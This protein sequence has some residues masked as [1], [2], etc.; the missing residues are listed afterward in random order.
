MIKFLQDFYGLMTNDTAKS[1]VT[2][3]FLE[4]YIFWN[5]GRACLILF[6][7]IFF[8]FLLRFIHHS[9]LFSSD[10]LCIWIIFLW[11]APCILPNYFHS[12]NR[13]WLFYFYNSFFDFPVKPLEV[14]S[15]YLILSKEYT[16]LF[17][18]SCSQCL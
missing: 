13:L 4:I 12:F 7:V 6:L 17:I 1:W 10:P 15:E 8:Y 9:F 2:C 18:L 11:L 5:F 16:T 14:R 3:H